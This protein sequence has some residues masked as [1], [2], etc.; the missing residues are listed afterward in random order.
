MLICHKKGQVDYVIYGR[1]WYR[2]DGGAKD[3]SSVHTKDDS[4]TGFS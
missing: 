3:V 2:A 1:Y 4:G